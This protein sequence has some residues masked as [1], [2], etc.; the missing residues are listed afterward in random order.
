MGISY[1]QV[2][3]SKFIG[4]DSNCKADYDC[5]K[6]VAQRVVKPHWAVVDVSHF[7]QHAVEVQGIDHTPS[8]SAQPGVVQQ[9]GR[10]FARK[11]KNSNRFINCHFLL[12]KIHWQIFNMIQN[13]SLTSLCTINLRPLS[14]TKKTISAKNTQMTKFLWM[15]FELVC[16]PPL[17]MESPTRTHSRVGID[18]QKA[19]QVTKSS[20]RVGSGTY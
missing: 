11:L 5:R 4:P 17:K 14:A 9:D 6:T 7:S 8:E 10:Q 2:V 18:R 13:K 20:K 3:I 1:L 15:E 19:I 12:S 16:A